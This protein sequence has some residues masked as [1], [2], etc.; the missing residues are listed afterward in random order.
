MPNIHFGIGR[1]P[2]IQGI[3]PYSYRIVS[4]GLA[5]EARKDCAA[6][7]SKAAAGTMP[8]ETGI[9][10]QFSQHLITLLKFAIPADSIFFN[11]VSP[12]TISFDGHRP[13]RALHKC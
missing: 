4:A 8:V 10:H 13:I 5:R 7:V 6:M 9:F 1:L 12:L 3:F 2:P 11:K